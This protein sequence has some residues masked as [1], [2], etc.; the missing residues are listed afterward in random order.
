ML[1]WRNWQKECSQPRHQLAHRL[2]QTAAL[3]PY[4]IDLDAML[5][6]PHGMLDQSGVPVNRA[7]GSYPEVYHPT[8]IAEYALACW[9]VYLYTKAEKYRDAFMSQVNWLIEHES[10]LAGGAGGWPI[11]FAVPAYN[12]LPMWLSALTQGIVLSVLIRA[13]QLTDE[14]RFLQVARRTVRTFERDIRDGGVASQIGASGIFFEEVAVEPASHVLNGY[15]LA[16]FGLY[17]Y[18]FCT[19]DSTIDALIQRSLTALHDLIADFDL[20]YWSLYD[21]HF[22]TPATLYYH[23][24]HVTLMEALVQITQCEHCAAL[25]SQWDR[26]Q[27]SCLCRWRY[28]VVSR[29]IRYRRALRRRITCVTFFAPSGMN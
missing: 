9:N 21:L 20:G 26:Y 17:D 16:L 6:L 11:P 5:A 8:T 13:Y 2:L 15:I 23:A 14:E 24:L 28:F 4:P 22:R 19:G 18:V 29:I 27:R 25:A 12:A 3:S 10:P 7:Y 1:E